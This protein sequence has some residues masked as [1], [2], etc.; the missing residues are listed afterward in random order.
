MIPILG[1]EGRGRLADLARSKVLLAFDF[2]GTLAPIVADRDAAFLRPTTRELLARVCTL[3]PCAVITGRGREDV[4]ARLLGMG[5]KH[6]VGN[7]GL[8]PSPGME[9][10]EDAIAEAHGELARHLA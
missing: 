7:H 5:M 2:D 8:E 10:F 4:S 3:Y 6:L 9:D 1:D